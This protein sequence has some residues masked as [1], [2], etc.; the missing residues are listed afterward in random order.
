MLYLG[1]IV[2]IANDSESDA[3][4]ILGDFNASPSSAH[5]NELHNMC[6]EHDLEI[7]DVNC[8]PADSYTHVNN[9]NYRSCS[10]LDH[11]VIS[12][13]IL[14]SFND[15]TID[16]GSAVSDHFPVLFSFCFEG[17]IVREVQDA[18]EKRY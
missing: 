7:A 16:Y 9:N 5:Y 15:C 1:K 4:C 2:A 17:Y 10:W 6:L 3:V 13:N 8:L 12:K 11:V 18:L 14:R